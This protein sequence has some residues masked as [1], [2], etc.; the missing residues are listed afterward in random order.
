[1]TKQIM[2]LTVPA[3]GTWRIIQ[4]ES[5]MNQFSVYYERDGHRKLISRHSC[6]QNALQAILEYTTCR[7]WQKTDV[8]LNKVW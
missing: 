2:K 5:D 1:M 3:N 6:I 4:N 7:M 8:E